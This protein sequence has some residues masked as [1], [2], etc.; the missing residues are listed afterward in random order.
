VAEFGRVWWSRHDEEV[1]PIEHWPSIEDCHE[2]DG[3]FSIS[4][5]N[6]TRRLFLT[7]FCDNGHEGSFSI[8]ENGSI[9]AKGTT[10]VASAPTIAEVDG[11]TFPAGAYFGAGHWEVECQTPDGG[12]Y[13]VVAEVLNWGST[14]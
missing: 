5:S 11:H 2:W 9:M 12:V 7:A 8:L 4:A 1:P 6:G 14:E 3:L 10:R 13:R